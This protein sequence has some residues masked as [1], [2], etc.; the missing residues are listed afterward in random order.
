MHSIHADTTNAYTNA[1]TIINLCILVYSNISFM[2]TA[3]FYLRNNKTDKASIYV[4]LTTGNKNQFR[5]SI[6]L[7]INPKYWKSESKSF[8]FPKNA[9]NPIIRNLKVDLN[10]LETH[11]LNEVN[12]A[13]TKGTIINNDWLKEQINNCFDRKTKTEIKTATENLES[14]KL[15]TQIQSF[16]NGAKTYIHSNGKVGLSYNRIKSIKLF[17]R[18]ITDY[19]KETQTTI[20]LKDIDF[21]VVESL[22]DW[23]LNIQGYSINY[24]GSIMRDL[25]V[26]CRYASKKKIEV[27][28]YTQYITTYKQQKSDKIIQTLSINELQII[29]DLKIDNERLNNARKWIVLGCNIGQRSAD[30]LKI[31]LKNFVTIS[32]KKYI[33]LTQEKTS[34]D[35]LIPIT[36]QCERILKTGI[37]YKISQ[38]KLNEY[39]KEVCELAE[40]NQVVEGDLYDKKT[41]RKVRGK[42]SKFQL[43]TSH[44]F[45]RSFSSNH[46]INIPTPLIMEITGHS[47]ESTFLEYI[48]K[49]VDKTRNANL[50]LELIELSEKKKV[51]KKETPI[52]VFKTLN[53]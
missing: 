28:S 23:I 35:V 51:S 30:L 9:S 47:K 48:N 7:T 41:K 52:K 36:K 4:N 38:Q 33:E 25:K 20:F 5:K 40:I 12:K 29:E 45:R 43:I 31:T 32:D 2:A 14:N 44:S 22:N 27:N 8:G 39:I 19:Q 13:N 42:Y 34:K 21:E 17:E 53:K 50:M 46:Y 49:P 24:G 18:I 16:K 10:K 37:P 1:Y 26:I 6:G 3:N 11:L 15:L